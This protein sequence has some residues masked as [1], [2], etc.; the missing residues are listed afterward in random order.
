MA[1]P[2]SARPAPS[3]GSRRPPA[4]PTVGTLALRPVVADGARGARPEPARP[5][6]PPAN[7]LFKRKVRL[8]AML[9]ELVRARELVFALVERDYRARYKQTKVG[10]AWAVVSPVLLMCAFTIFS[11]TVADFDTG[12]MPYPL[13]AYV[14]LVPWTFFASSVSQGS[15]SITSNLS[16]GNKVYCPREVFPLAAIGTAAMDAVISLSVLFALFAVYGEAPQAATVWVPVLLVVQVTFTVG[17]TLAL[18]SLVVYLRDL[19]QILPMALQF[20][21][22]ATPVAFSFDVLDT[23]WQALV[24]GLNPLAPVIDGYR[25]AVV[26]GNAPVWDLVGIAAAA[27]AAWLVLGYLLFKRLETGFADVA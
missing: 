21:L 18:A 24:A 25:E 11:S 3:N 2:R 6:G 8:L 19:R 9:R 13:F 10:V 15:S 22:F 5:D 16:L 4:G 27:S 26:F 20:G 17:L 12:G 1:A 23:R 7:L 14:A